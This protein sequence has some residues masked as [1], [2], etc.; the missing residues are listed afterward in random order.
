MQEETARKPLEWQRR[1]PPQSLGSSLP[2]PLFRAKQASLNNDPPLP[3]LQTVEQNSRTN[4][5]ITSESDEEL[6]AR[7][8]TLTFTSLSPRPPCGSL[9]LAPPAFTRLF[10]MGRGPNLTG[11]SNRW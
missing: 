7:R 3:A 5:T 4:L 11:T 1:A 10:C 2:V 8:I 6:Q 9:E